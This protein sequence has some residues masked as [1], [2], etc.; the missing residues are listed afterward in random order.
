SD[1]LFDA[2]EAATDTLL[3]YYAGHG[4]TSD[5]QD[6]RLALR[7]AQAHR[8]GQWL[9]YADIRRAVGRSPAQRRIVI[10]D[11]CHGGRAIDGGMSTHMGDVNQQALGE[12]LFKLADIDGAAVLTAA[13][14]VEKAMCP[15]D[16]ELSAFTREL[17]DLLRNGVTGPI[18][19]HPEGRTGEQLRLLD[20]TTVHACLRER[21]T[22]RVV[23]EQLLPEPQL[24]TRN[25]GGVI[26]LGLNPAY[27][28]AVSMPPA[29]APVGVVSNL[30][31]PDQLFFGRDEDLARL[32]LSAETVIAD[33]RPVTWL[34]HGMGGVG[35]TALIEQAAAKVKD[36]FPDGRI[37]INLNGFE[38]VTD[39]EGARPG[40]QPLNS[41][42]ALERLL[43]LVGHSNIPTDPARRADEWRA[44]LSGRRVLLI[45]DNAA[46]AQTIIPLL[47]GADAQCLTLIS[48]RNQDFPVPPER[49]IGLGGISEEAAVA[50]LRTAGCKAGDADPGSLAELARR[51]CCLP[52][53][54]RPIGAA[55]KN[56]TVD[57]VLAAM[58]DDALAEF[59]RADA[60]VRRA[61]QVS[62]NALPDDL[63]AVL[64]HC[65]WHPGRTYSTAGMAAMLGVS[66]GKAALRL[67][68]LLDVHLLQRAQ[69][70]FT[71]H[72]LYLPLAREAAAVDAPDGPR[73]AR[74]RLS[75]YL[76]THLTAALMELYREPPEGT[77]AAEGTRFEGPQAALAWLHN[78]T[79]ELEA[80]ASAA[81]RDS[82]AQASGLVTGTARWLGYADRYDTAAELYRQ[83]LDLAT[84]TANRHGTTQALQ[85]HADCHRMQNEYDTAADHYRQA[86]DLATTTGDCL[87]QANALRGVADCHLMQDEYDTAADH[88]R[89][90]LDLATTTGN[91]NGQ[92]HAIEG[93]ADYHLMQ[94]EYDTAAELYRQVLDLATTTGNRHGRTQA[95]QGLADC[96]R[97]QDAY[98]PAHDPTLHSVPPRPTSVLRTGQTNALQ[99]L[100]HCHRMQDEYDTAADHYRQALDLATT[101]G[102]RIGQANAL[103]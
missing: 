35:K 86:L 49:C 30:T 16:W 85:G 69:G 82:W 58:D 102:D 83:V 4:D 64:H 18:P 75:D 46:D 90:A 9:R 29:S 92:T 40:A 71:F 99:G 43:S 44:W 100:A 39:T 56:S 15:P 47:P 95:L 66:R 53:V 97:M 84:T 87:G 80:A 96:H 65:A 5:G 28:G 55:L 27:T 33:G 41:G 8:P 19:N 68:R 94:D 13:S 24:G 2:A 63:R 60:A 36:R 23:G 6:L 57:D 10:L 20:I 31:A 79:A 51:C 34:V 98:D 17:V 32:E 42:Q 52:V 91:R 14:G 7:G 76:L 26:A 67:G 25:Q 59:P 21:L 62:Y 11:F 37:E 77:A 74:T 101:T 61:F 1:E 103:W 12:R 50:L 48:S 72:D 38:Y 70:A 81:V 54:L 73:S 93:L 45:L 88:Y 89:Q 3:I 22:G 78:H